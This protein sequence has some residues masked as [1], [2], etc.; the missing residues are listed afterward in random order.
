MCVNE[1][2]TLTPSP[3]AHSQHTLTCEVLYWYMQVNQ[4]EWLIHLLAKVLEWMQTFYDIL[5]EAIVKLEEQLT[6]AG[7]ALVAAGA[8]GQ[9]WV[10]S[11]NYISECACL[12]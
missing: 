9:E 6:S 3:Q 7:V 11:G 5:Q 2:H 12:L 1:A 10:D 4:Q 8:E